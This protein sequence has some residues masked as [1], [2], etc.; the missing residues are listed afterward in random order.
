M[1][2]ENSYS[3]WGSNKMGLKDTIWNFGIREF[4]QT[5]ECGR[6]LLDN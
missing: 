5:K 3:D 2:P 1:D 4:S 6:A